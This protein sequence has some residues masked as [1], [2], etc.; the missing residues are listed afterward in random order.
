MA[1][2]EVCRARLSKGNVARSTSA[3]HRAHRVHR[4]KR[5]DKDQRLNRPLRGE[6]A[7]FHPVLILLFPPKRAPRRSF[8]FRS[9]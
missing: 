5:K 1:G 4:H 7:E 3:L 9:R 6:C 2:R 8:E